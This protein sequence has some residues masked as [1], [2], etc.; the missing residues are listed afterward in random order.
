MPPVKLYLEEFERRRE[1][2]KAQKKEN[3][4]LKNKRLPQVVIRT[5]C[6]KVKGPVWKFER[7]YKVWKYK[8]EGSYE[9][10]DSRFPA[11][12]YKFLDNA[13]KEIP[14]K[15]YAEEFPKYK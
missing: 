8:F 3:T 5:E 1:V 15:A 9:V 4:R 7:I 13:W 11:A 2:E 6:E 10:W 14:S 12:T